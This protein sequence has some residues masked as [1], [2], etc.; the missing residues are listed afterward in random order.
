[1]D[2]PRIEGVVATYHDVTDRKKIEKQKQEFI[3]IASH[4]LKTP[5]TSLKAYAQILEDT[6]IKAKDK[7]SAELLEKMNNQVD[8][9]TTLITDLLDFT[10][11]QEEK[12]KLREEKYNINELISEV[13]EEMQRTTKTHKI[14]TKLDKSV[15]MWGDRYR[16]GQVLTNL[17]SNAVKYSPHA[18]KI[19]VSSKIDSNLI[20]I[21]VEDLGIGIKKDVLNKVF[22]RFFRVTESK[23]NTFPGLGLGLYIAAEIV[24]RQGGTITVESTEGKGSIFCFTLPLETHDKEK[25]QNNV[26]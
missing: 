3:S 5:V 10:R 25:K 26:N 2:N 8:R 13:V 17:L 1:L 12:L 9:L 23:M 14:I 16:T 11:I 18:K 21:C 15:Q 7:R 22:D 6:F 20:S 24:K 19:I 4:E